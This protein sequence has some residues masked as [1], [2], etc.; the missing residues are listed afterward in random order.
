MEHVVVCRAC[1]ARHDG[2]DA[3]TVCAS[4]GAV[5]PVHPAA[6]PFARLGVK[7]PR[8]AVDDAT[9]E[10]AWLQRSRQVHPDRFARRADADRRAA[11]EQTAALNDAWRALRGAFARAVWLVRSVG[12]D[13]PRL[14]S[15]ALVDLMEAREEAATSPEARADVVAR[16]EARF[17]EVMAR[18]AVEL[19]AV[20]AAGGWAGAAVELPR[21][22]RAAALLA[23]ARTLARLV[24]DLGGP[25][26]IPGLEAR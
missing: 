7:P 17:A 4:C 19:G 18:V 6:S 24:A 14:P 9:L 13:E 10:R 26:L 16:S 8:F 11:A 15:A 20:D 5:L 1:S 12:V 2:A 25:T 22:R 23:E 21:V 3:P